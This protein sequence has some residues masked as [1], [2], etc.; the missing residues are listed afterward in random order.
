[1]PPSCAGWPIMSYSTA[2]AFSFSSSRIG[3]NNWRRVWN[4]R[5]VGGHV[6]SQCPARSFASPH[7]PRARRCACRPPRPCAHRNCAVGNE[8]D[9]LQK[10]QC[11]VA[12]ASPAAP[13]P[14]IGQRDLAHDGAGDRRW[15]RSEHVSYPSGALAARVGNGRNNDSSLIEP[16]EGSC[17]LK[18]ALAATGPPRYVCRYGTPAG[19]HRSGSH[20][21]ARCRGRCVLVDRGRAKACC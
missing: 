9:L 6:A 7:A 16:V 21:R 2:S 4:A 18:V 17:C 5:A 10:R 8:R 19:F 11:C 15:R 1:M 20:Y 12:I 13:H 14:A 3:T